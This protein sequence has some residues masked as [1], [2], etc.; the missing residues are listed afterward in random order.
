MLMRFH[1]GF[2]VGH[3]YAHHQTPISTLPGTSRTPHPDNDSSGLEHDDS[4]DVDPAVNAANSRPDSGESDDND[5]FPNQ[6]VDLDA[7]E[8]DHGESADDYSDDE[9]LMCFDEMY[10]CDAIEMDYE[11]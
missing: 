10:G 5:D 4:N 9:A 2:G 6:D 1:Y 3:S 11:N 8:D 7:W